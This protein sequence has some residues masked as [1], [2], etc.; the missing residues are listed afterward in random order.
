[1]WTN[2][3]WTTPP[4]SQIQFDSFLDLALLLGTFSI[5]EAPKLD[6]GEVR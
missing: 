1:M 6:V 3:A 2:A 4:N 5:S